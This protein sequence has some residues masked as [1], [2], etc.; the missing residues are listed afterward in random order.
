MPPRAFK[1]RGNELRHLTDATLPACREAKRKKRDLD[2]L[3]PCNGIANGFGKARSS[4]NRHHRMTTSGG[5]C[6]IVLSK[7]FILG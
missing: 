1:G 6:R 4:P 3:L 5:R 7:P 2:A